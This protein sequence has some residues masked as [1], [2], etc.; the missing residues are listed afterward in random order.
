M[1][2]VGECRCPPPSLLKPTHLP[3]ESEAL[4]ILADLH[5]GGDQQNELV[6][7]EFEEIKHQVYFEKTE[8]AKSFTDL[9]KPGVLRRVGLGCSLQMWSQLTGMNVR[10][11]DLYSTGM[12]FD[13]GEWVGHDVLYHL[14]LPRR[15]SHRPS[16]Q[17]HRG[18]SPIHP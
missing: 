16:R 12:G 5:G 13:S 3:R 14:R 6:V 2:R 15:R 4:E 1:I 17:S 10:R 8:G 9:L 18:L 11:S 7:L